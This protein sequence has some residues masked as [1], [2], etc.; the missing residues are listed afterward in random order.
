MGWCLDVMCT[1]LA[2]CGDKSHWTNQRHKLQLGI[3]KIYH[4]PHIKNVALIIYLSYIHYVIFVV[5]NVD[6]YLTQKQAS[7]MSPPSLSRACRNRTVSLC[8]PTGEMGDRD[9]GVLLGD[10]RVWLQNRRC[11]RE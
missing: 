9:I 11:G 2:A 5:R 6:I 4:F 3:S 8:C 7:S 10:R 1:V